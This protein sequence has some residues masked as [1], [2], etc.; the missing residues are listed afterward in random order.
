MDY[1]YGF[2]TE[3]IAGGII[4]M[5]N[6]DQYF[7]TEANLPTNKKKTADENA[8]IYSHV[9]WLDTSKI[10]G[11]YAEIV[12]ILNPGLILCPLSTILMK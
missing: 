8:G 2:P 5:G 12:F 1:K 6:Y 11:F 10:Q 7:M 9:A 4:T 3:N